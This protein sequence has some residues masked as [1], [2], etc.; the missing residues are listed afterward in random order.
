[1]QATKIEL[2]AQLVDMVT[3]TSPDAAVLDDVK[4]AII[5][6]DSRLHRRT[7]LLGEAT[8]SLH[9]GYNEMLEAVHRVQQG[10]D[11]HQNVLT[12]LITQSNALRDQVEETRE[13]IS[14][15]K[16]DVTEA[17]VGP[18]QW[19]AQVQAHIVQI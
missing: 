3:A 11:A 2:P 19:K 18:L 14:E 10:L 4:A 7:N 13:H 12:Q 6:L 16:H 5:E 1:M 15:S 9:E 8:S 17:R